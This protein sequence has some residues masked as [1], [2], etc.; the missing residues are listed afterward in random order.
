L[1]YL[2]SKSQYRFEDP[3]TYHNA[4]PKITRLVNCTA[5]KDSRKCCENTKFPLK[6]HRKYFIQKIQHLS[7]L[8]G[9]EDRYKFDQLVIHPKGMPGR[10]HTIC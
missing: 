4:L 10:I 3:H 2:L 6:R 8:R 1:L 5:E 9:T 7:E